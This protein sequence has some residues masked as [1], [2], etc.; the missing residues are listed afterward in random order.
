MHIER[1]NRP[2]FELD[3]AHPAK[4][5]LTAFIE[6][7]SNCVGRELDPPGQTPIDQE[8][9][10]ATDGKT[11]TFSAFAYRYL[12]V[13]IVVDGFLTN[14]PRWTPSELGAIERLPQYRALMS[15]CAQAAQ[16]SGNTD[17]LEL[18]DEVVGMLKLWDEYLEFRR[19]TVE[20]KPAR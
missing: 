7:R 11:W 19:W 6:C 14:A 12:S 3:D 2:V 5:F 20:G 13:D 18:V 1:L 17:C 15:E 10:S 4:Q 8:W 16:Q 9:Q